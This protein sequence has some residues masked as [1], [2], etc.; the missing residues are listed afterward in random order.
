M[1]MNMI[2]LLTN[3][4]LTTVTGISLN[5]FEISPELFQQHYPHKFGFIKS[6]ARVS[7]SGKS[8]PQLRQLQE[9]SRTSPMSSSSR[10]T[11]R[12]ISPT[13]FRFP[14]L[15]LLFLTT[16]NQR[17]TTPLPWQT[18][19]QSPV[20]YYETWTRLDISSTSTP[21]QSNGQP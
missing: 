13:S 9:S 21:Q 14:S 10:P 5:A 7:I 4:C 8:P 1:Y 12:I 18:T 15:S 17:T 3:A 11:T 19:L 2:K 20:S 6:S 16:S